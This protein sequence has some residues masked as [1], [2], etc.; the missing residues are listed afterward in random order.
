MLF[1]P[2][3][4]WAVHK[5]PVVVT[6]VTGNGVFSSST[7]SVSVPGSPVSGNLLILVIGG[8]NGPSGSSISTP[9][10]WTLLTSRGGGTASTQVAY[11]FYKTA[12]GSEGSTVTITIT[13]TSGTAS[14]GSVGYQ[15]SGWSGTPQFGTF[16]TGTSTS[17]DPPSVTPTAGA[18]LALALAAGGNI[19]NNQSISAYP[20]G[21][22]NGQLG[23][24]TSAANRGWCAGAEATISGTSAVNPGAYTT[25]QSSSWW[26]Q[27]LIVNGV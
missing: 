10:G 18:S 8:Y 22:S 16:A 2:A 1:V 26:A 12:S 9:S 6:R 3:V 15:I 7:A 19:S 11:I 24:N 14:W 5:P 4:A 23:N 17:P 21:Y 27:T 20:S 25:G 13:S